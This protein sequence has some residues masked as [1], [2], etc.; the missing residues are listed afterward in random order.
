MTQ[1][2]VATELHV[3]FPSIEQWW[4]ADKLGKSQGTKPR[5]GRPKL[6]NRVSKI[7]ITISL[8]KRGK[9]HEKLRGN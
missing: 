7:I 1:K 6:L 4:R 8:R 3:S 9:L 5:C 2:K